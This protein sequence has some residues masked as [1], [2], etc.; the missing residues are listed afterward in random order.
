MKV[1]LCFANQSRLL[2]LIR[3]LLG[4]RDS[5]HPHLLGILPYLKHWFISL[6]LWDFN[7]FMCSFEK[8]GINT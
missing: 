5:G 8:H 3:L 4:C 7:M 2:A 6:S 1:G